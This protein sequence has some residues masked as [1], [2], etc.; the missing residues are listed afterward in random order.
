MM[1]YLTLGYKSNVEALTNGKIIII[2]F[3]RLFVIHE[4]SGER[5]ESQIFI[6]W[7]INTV[8]WLYIIIHNLFPLNSV[9]TY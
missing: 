7:F 2:L 8:L 3:L 6:Y 1:Y 5:D 4:E 9:T